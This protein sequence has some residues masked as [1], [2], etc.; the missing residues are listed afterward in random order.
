MAATVQAAKPSELITVYHWLV[1]ILAAC[2]WIFDCMGQCI[3]VLGREPAMRELLGSAAT[4]HKVWFWGTLATTALMIGWGTGGLIFGMMSDR[5]GRVKAMIATLFAYTVFSAVSG[6]SHTVV[7]FIVYRFL[8][9]LGVGGM[10]SSH[11]PGRRKRSIEGSNRCLGID[12]GPLCFRQYDRVRLKP[13]NYSRR[14][15]FLGTF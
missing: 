11:H 2:G 10:L 9:G 12:A 15:G 8:F 1:V 7:E 4:D 3:F 14:R 6:F 5:Y 13:E